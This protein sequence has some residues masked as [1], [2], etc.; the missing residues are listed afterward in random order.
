[1][2]NERTNKHHIEQNNCA[3]DTNILNKM[4]IVINILY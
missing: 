4:E 2:F 1:M 3:E